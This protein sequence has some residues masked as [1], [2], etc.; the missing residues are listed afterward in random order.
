MKKTV[1]LL[2]AIV[3]LF[4]EGCGSVGGTTTLNTTSD[5]SSF[6][7]TTPSDTNKNDQKNQNDNKNTKVSN[8][9]LYKQSTATKEGLVISEFMTANVNTK[10][11]PDFRQFSDWIELC[12]NSDKSLNTGGYRITDKENSI[13]WKIPSLSVPAHGYV[14]L[15]ADKK[16]S[17]LHTD[18]SLDAKGDSIFLY[19]PNGNLIDSVVFGKQKGDI[20]AGRDLKTFQWGYMLPTFGKENSKLIPKIR[21]EKPNFSLESGFYSDAQL[22]TLTTSDNSEIH[23]EVDG[24]IPTKASPLYSGALSVQKSTVIKAISY[25][26]GFLPGKVVTKNYFINEPVMQES[27][28]PVVSLSIS[29]DYLFDKNYGIYIE[30]KENPSSSSMH[31]EGKVSDEYNYNQGWKRPVTIEYFDKSTQPVNFHISADISMSGECSL[32][33]PKRS[34]AFKLKKKYGKS[35]L[36]YPLYP[37]KDIQKFKDF[38]LRTGGNGYG[39]ADVLAASLVADGHLDIDYEAFRIVHMF[40]NGEYWGIYH[41]REKKGKDFIHANYPDVDSD[42]LDIIS[43]AEAKEGD[44]TDYNYL[45]S[46]TKLDLTISENYQKVVSKIDIDN[47]IDY[48]SLMI[49]CG[50]QDWLSNNT[51]LWKEKKEGAKWRWILDDVDGGLQAWGLNHNLFTRIAEKQEYLTAALFTALSKNSTFKQRF[52][53]R[54]VQLMDNQ[55][56]AQNIIT[57]VNAL[58]KD[59]KRYMRYEKW[60]KELSKHDKTVDG[61]VQTFDEHI[62][63]MI[64]FAK[65]RKDIV[66]QQLASY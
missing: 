15:W 7:E 16:N 51:R 8:D 58:T 1:L 46:L 27:P 5:N 23:Y 25:K 30:G 37:Q 39:M 62:Q 2:S 9:P 11:D 59:E 38:K 44:M 61:F 45:S 64:D 55:F 47:F 48:M 12:N 42:N 66:L 52:H 54:L 60:A 53:D 49:F 40:V 63:S 20:S 50:A 36:E 65:K 24:S 34:L 13:G 29:E 4:T 57:H 26:E 56:S 28:F 21:C 22:V 3:F 35:K 43:V 41:I 33:F 14:V 10:M 32:Q 6:Q 18:F 31:C 17:K 19:N